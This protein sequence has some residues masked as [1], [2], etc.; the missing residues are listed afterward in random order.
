MT[1]VVCHFFRKK[2]PRL[3]ISTSWFGFDPKSPSR[4]WILWIHDP[5]LDS[6]IRIW[7]FPEKV[8]FFR[9]YLKCASWKRWSD[10]SLQLCWI[11]RIRKHERFSQL[12]MSGTI[13]SQ[14]KSNQFNIQTCLH[15]QYTFFLLWRSFFYYYY[16]F[17]FFMSENSC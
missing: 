10:L 2:T 3:W 11:P 14:K 15:A 1:T 9:L 4:V 8:P 5:F 16:Y 7:I 17:F 13:V 12:C 6:E